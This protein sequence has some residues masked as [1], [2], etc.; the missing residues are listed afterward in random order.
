V[1]V[2]VEDIRE[3]WLSWGGVIKACT[4]RGNVTSKE[5]KNW[6]L[7]IKTLLE[8]EYYSIL[9]VH[10]CIYIIHVRNFDCSDIYNLTTVKF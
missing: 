6:F 3:K 10:F 4:L 5:E 2:K 9:V 7:G 1:V 8:D